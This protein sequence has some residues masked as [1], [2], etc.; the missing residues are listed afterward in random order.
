MAVAGPELAVAS[1]LFV[2]QGPRFDVPSVILRFVLFWYCK[3]LL[4]ELK[5]SSCYCKGVAQSC[6]LNF[7]A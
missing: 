7:C 6:D 2:A 3:E 5:G 1:I 4:W